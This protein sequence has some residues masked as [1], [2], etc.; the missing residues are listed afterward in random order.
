MKI[1]RM[2]GIIILLRVIQGVIISPVRLCDAFQ[3]VYMDDYDISN[4]G[5]KTSHE[6]Q[7]TQTIRI[8]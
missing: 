1:F 2:L 6:R 7:T 4:Q 5:L 3:L 8:P